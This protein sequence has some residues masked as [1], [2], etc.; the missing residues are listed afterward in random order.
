ML[1]KLLSY[2]LW[3]SFSRDM[4][5]RSQLR[6]LLAAWTFVAILS[7]P[8]FAQATKTAKSPTSTAPA[9]K[10]PATAGSD[11]KS[12]K[13]KTDLV[14]LNSASKDDLSALPGIGPVLSQKI[15][16]GRP[17]RAKTDLVRKKVV[18]QATYNKIAPL[19]IAKQSKTAK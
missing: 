8:V 13:T 14:D 18:P 3:R 7:A 10:A 6:V 17:Y 19:V 12:A 9:S 5:L 15:I 2:D 4:K 11:I 1:K 16:D